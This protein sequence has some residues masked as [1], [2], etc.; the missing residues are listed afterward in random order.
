METVFKDV[1]EKAIKLLEYAGCKV[2]TKRTMLLWSITTISVILYKLNLEY[3]SKINTKNIYQP[4][5]HLTNVQ[6]VVDEPYEL[7]KNIPG[8]QYIELKDKD[9][10]CGSAGIYNIEQ[11]EKSMLILENKVKQIKQILPKIIVTTNPGCHLQMKLGVKKAYLEDKVKV[12]HLVELLTEA[13]II[14]R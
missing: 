11:F 7:M 10:C 14:E 5:C 9:L 12:V 6:K 8:K 13:C 3:K 2:T 4:S 1:K